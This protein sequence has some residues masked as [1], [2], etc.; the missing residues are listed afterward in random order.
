METTENNHFIIFPVLISALMILVFLAQDNTFPFVGNVIL[1][2]VL[3]GLSFYFAPY[4][5]TK[6][7]EVIISRGVDITS[8]LIMSVTCAYVSILI[9]TH[10]PNIITFGHLLAIVSSLFPYYVWY[11][12]KENSRNVSVSHFI[13]AFFLIGLLRFSEL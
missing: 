5:I 13:V 9:F 8:N 7:S 6:S 1:S 4:R 12:G 10:S 2:A 11:I 3:I